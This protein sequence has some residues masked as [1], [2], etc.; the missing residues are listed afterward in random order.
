VDVL[1]ADNDKD[2]YL[3]FQHMEINLHAVIRA[4]ILEE[5]TCHHQ[6]IPYHTIP[7]LTNTLLWYVQI[8]KRYILYQSLKALHFIH[9][10]GLLHRD[11]KVTNSNHPLP[12]SSN[13]HWFVFRL[14]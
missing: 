1:R 3:V 9:S 8:H 5:V 13:A 14:F 7:T 4:N 10:G 11:M 12:R 2:I 6:A